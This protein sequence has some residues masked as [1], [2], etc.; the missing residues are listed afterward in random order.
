MKNS[1]K[2]IFLLLTAAIILC[3]LCVGVFSA[4]AENDDPA[5]SYVPEIAENEDSTLDLWFEHSF[6]KVL[7][8]D[9]TPS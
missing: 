9:T 6:K 2:K 8:H 1:V 7:T 5:Y 3:A 4:G